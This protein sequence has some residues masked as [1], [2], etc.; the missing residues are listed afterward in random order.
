MKKRTKPGAPRMA[1]RKGSTDGRARYSREPAANPSGV[2]AHSAG[3]EQSQL[4]MDFES[5][6]VA[7]RRQSPDLVVDPVRAELSGAGHVGFY[8]HVPD[9]DRRGRLGKS[10][11]KSV[12]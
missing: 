3:C 11:R 5:H 10:D 12:V 4:R 2:G 6:R 1:R 8:A 9:F 7:V